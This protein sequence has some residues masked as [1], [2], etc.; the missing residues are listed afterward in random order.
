MHLAGTNFDVSVALS[1]STDTTGALFRQTF[2]LESGKTYIVVASGTV[3]SGTYTPATPFSLEVITDA[4]E[5]AD[6]AGK[7]DVLVWHGAT[8]A[9]TVDVAETQVGAG[10]IVDDIAYGEAQGYLSL[11]AADFDLEIRNMAGDTALFGYDAD[12]TMLGDS[13]ITVLASGFV[14]TTANNGGANFGLWVALASGGNL[15][16]LPTLAVGLEEIGFINQMNLYPNP[17]REMITIDLNSTESN[18]LTYEVL[19]LSG[20]VM[21]N[22]QV[23]V[24]PGENK[25][26]FDLSNLP[27]GYYFVRIRSEEQANVMPFLKR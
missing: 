10:T 14:D 20:S 22:K 19:N 9:P 1:N 18:E 23:Q 12:L 21:M 15:I 25:Y 17:V 6:T 7:V 13:A 8:D 5:M 4:K 3:G 24:L 27:S 11:P 16:E 26:T 2:L